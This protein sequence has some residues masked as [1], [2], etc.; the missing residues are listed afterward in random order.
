MVYFLKTNT[1]SLRL[2]LYIT[3]YINPSIASRMR[4]GVSIA[5]QEKGP[6]DFFLLACVCCMLMPLL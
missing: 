5:E 3:P 1:R 4:G 2:N 6:K